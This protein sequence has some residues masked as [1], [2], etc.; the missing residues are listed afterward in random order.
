MAATCIHD[1]NLGPVTHESLRRFLVELHIHYV[2][3]SCITQASPRWQ[4]PPGVLFPASSLFQKGD[5]IAP[6]MKKSLVAPLERQAS[7]VQF[8]WPAAPIRK[9]F[10]VCA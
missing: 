3:K 7:E 4:G 1:Q 8:F 2:T 5:A 6:Q 10:A 9:G